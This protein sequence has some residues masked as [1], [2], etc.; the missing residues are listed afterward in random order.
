MPKF[1]GLLGVA[2]MVAGYRDAVNQIQL[3]SFSRLTERAV[4]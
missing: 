2:Q 4:G 3:A 1:N